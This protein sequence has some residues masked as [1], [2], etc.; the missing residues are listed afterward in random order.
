MKV[1]T[2][3]FL[4]ETF[5]K[6][7]PKTFRVEEGQIL[8]PSA[9]QLLGD[10]RVEIVRDGQKA[11]AAEVSPEVTKVVEEEK[12]VKN[13]MFS[14]DGGAFETKPEHMTSFNG[15]RLVHKDHP[16]IV[17][18]GKLETLKAM[19]VRA[20]YSINSAGSKKLVDDL[21]EILEKTAGIIRAELNDGVML[22]TKIIG[23][24]KRE[25]K[26]QLLD[27]VKYFGIDDFEVGFEMGLNLIELNIL[28]SFVREVETAA[29]TAFKSEFEFEK[30]DLIQTLNLMSSALGIM[31]LREKAGKYS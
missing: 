28:R 1:I 7:I 23:L 13:Y 31:M 21:G 8:T 25:I 27:P 6:E 24:T 11:V 19:I 2:E 15:N 3:S 14:A 4:R 16:R 30:P 12:P 17:F 9:A 22:E 26:E 5:R 20:Q 10:K 18:R 29:V